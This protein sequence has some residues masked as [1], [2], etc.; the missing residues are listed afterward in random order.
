MTPLDFESYP[1]SH[2]LV[3]LM[4]VGRARGGHLPL[5]RRRSATVTALLVIMG[6]VLSHWVLDVGIASAGHAARAGVWTEVRT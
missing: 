4:R 2:S 6:V 1:Y 3:A 5:V